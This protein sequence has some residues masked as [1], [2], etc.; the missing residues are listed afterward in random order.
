MPPAA[1]VCLQLADETSA[2]NTNNTLGVSFYL[3]TIK[4]II[5][6]TQTDVDLK[7]YLKKV[8]FKIFSIPVKFLINFNFWSIYIRAC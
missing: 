4:K 3:F 8:G 7:V 5:C 2:T 1:D 6:N